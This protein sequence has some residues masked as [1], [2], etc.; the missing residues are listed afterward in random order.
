VL[1][2]PREERLLRSFLTE[3]AGPG[4]LL[5]SGEAGIGKSTLW[6]LGIGA[7]V[8][9]GQIVLTTRAA[10]SEVTLS[11]AG[12]GDL[13]DPV[14][15][16]VLD[17]LPSVQRES[18]DAALLRSA[19]PAPPLP[20]VIG[21]ALLAVL[22]L[23][24]ARA[25]VLVAVDDLQWLDAASADAVAFALRRLVDEPVR[26]LGSV[27]TSSALAPAVASSH[28]PV[29]GLSAALP[30]G[31]IEILTMDPLTD[32]ELGELLSARLGLTMPAVTLHELHE[33]TGGN[34]FWGL[35]VA[36]AFAATG[37]GELPFPESLS[38][39]V[40]RRL[41]DLTRPAR[42]ALLVVSALAHPTVSVAQR[43]LTELVPDPR[44]ALDAAVDAGVLDE[45]GGR[46][47]PAHPLLA[48][49]ALL[50]LPPGRRSTLHRHLADVVADREQRARHLALA[51]NGEPSAQLAADLD[52]GVSTAR[53]RGAA[54][55][56][57]EL[58]ELAV[59][60]T[61][62]RQ[63]RQRAARELI[64]AEV[65]YE[66]GE[67]GVAQ[68]LAQQAAE[69]G[70]RQVG[71]PALCLLSMITYY[72]EGSGTARA[73][74][75]QALEAA[76]G[77][78]VQRART[79]AALADTGDMGARTDLANALESLALVEDAPRGPEVSRIRIEALLASVGAR[80]DLAQG[81]DEEA[82]ER[83]V[84]EEAT[85]ALQSPIL[86]QR[87]AIQ[88]SFW[89]KIVDQLD[90]SRSAMHAAIRI[91]RDEGESSALSTLLGHLALNECWAGRYDA[92]RDAAD[93]GIRDA[94]RT[95]SAPVALYG[96]TGLVHVLTGE[97][98]AGREIVRQQ[99]GYGETYGHHRAVI[100]RLHVL[101][102]ADL[103]EGE[104][105]QA[106][107][108]LGQAY[109]IARSN[110]I[111]EPGRRHRLEA[112]LG[113]A[114]VTLGK[115]DRAA[116][117][118]AEQ[119]DLGRSADRPG[120]LAVGLRISGLTRAAEGELDEALPLLEESLE[121]ANRSPFPLERGRTLLALGSLHR[122][123][124]AKQLARDT[125]S[126]ARDCFATLGTPPW[127]AIADD[128]LRRVAGAHAGDELTES[129]VRVAELVV[130]GRTNREVAAELFTSV[131]TVEGHLASVYRKLGIR[132]RVALAQHL[133]P[134]PGGQNR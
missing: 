26:L 53:S 124:R 88:T 73:Y 81:L 22:R 97:L 91:A 70:D 115:L 8:G 78:P 37:A 50:G 39:S 12:L 30:V 55:A 42:E 25:P 90:R 44:A 84:A 28:D 5:V 9:A 32:T 4:A 95:G 71:V 51:A 116:E 94:D 47:H 85:R 76:N 66:L 74:L 104:V 125:L 48:S 18:L 72:L 105:A 61:P 102:L 126:A 108:V 89:F 77:D 99:L 2:R 15:D 132:S 36:R 112:D 21:A 110:E 103:L 67:W 34:P 80:L 29:G 92:A 54:R 122:R 10:D 27:R 117:L 82:L 130:T 98:D 46:L 56:A 111:A 100:A 118:A 41:G 19:A 11:F 23:L 96:A 121:A 16:D 83:S 14:P 17:A 52:T 133:S 119:I 43:A 129:E 62:S 40:E 31:S 58:A 123:R 49:G 69:H 3:S 13:L 7:A 134:V 60:L 93:E 109:E 114:W 127:L 106:A 101:G 35:V 86:L 24:A 75:E 120:V 68:A 113:Q 131:R 33:R 1:P 63:L 107:E 20:R 87:V 65:R 128:E 38:A 59:V 6:G 64:A 79:L 45:T 57:A